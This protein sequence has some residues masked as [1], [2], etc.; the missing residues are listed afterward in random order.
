M[1][2]LVVLG[3]TCYPSILGT[4]V[5][6]EVVRIEI[7]DVAG[8]LTTAVSSA[9]LDVK[10]SGGDT[11]FAR[12]IRN[13]AL[14]AFPTGTWTNYGPDGSFRMIR[15]VCKNKTIELSS[16]QVPSDNQATIAK[17]KTFNDIDAQLMK[18]FT[19]TPP[20]NAPAQPSK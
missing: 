13:Q 10:P 15:I 8:N 20:A 9:L 4:L 5:Y 12:T 17:R 19:K 7:V 14:S 3:A 6:G 16:W 11:Q 2:L 18:R 1:L